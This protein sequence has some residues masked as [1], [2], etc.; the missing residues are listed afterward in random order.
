ML[1]PVIVYT[2]FASTIIVNKILLQQLPATLFIAIRMLAGGLILF[3]LSYKN[4]GRLRWTNFKKDA[5][6]IISIA[7]FTSFIPALLKAYGLK[8]LLVAKT[9][10]I[11]SFDQCMTAIYAYL[12]LNERLTLK[13]VLGISIVFFGIFLSCIISSPLE[14]MKDAFFVFSYPELA[15]L[16]YVV[17][18]RFGWTLTGRTLKKDHYSTREL[19]SMT[20]IIS[21]VLASGLAFWT[22]DYQ[23]SLASDASWYTTVG[24]LVYTII[25]GNVAGYTLYGLMLKR[26]SA[27]FVTLSGFVSPIFV[28][29]L[30]WLI[31]GEP[32]SLSLCLSAIIIFLGLYVF[33]NQETA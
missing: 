29:T 1:L 18:S 28:A 23:V 4:S 21:G 8:N 6:L 5:G 17:V 11:G 7:L 14:K 3:L 20:M 16:G 19:T 31:L 26:H 13:K 12:L 22:G 33:Y 32:V 27:N 25:A 24:L 9:M 30:A 10:L 15:I 2:L